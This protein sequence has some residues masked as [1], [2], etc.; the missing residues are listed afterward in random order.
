MK[1]K[2]LIEQLQKFDDDL[3]CYVYADHGQT[4][5]R[6]GGAI[7]NYIPKHEIGEYYVES[8]HEDYIEDMN[9]YQEICIISD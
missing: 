8:I 9:D 3:E 6:C 4:D 1:V 2:E 5:I 7:N